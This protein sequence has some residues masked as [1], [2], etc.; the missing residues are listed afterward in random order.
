M[1]KPEDFLGAFT[2]LQ[3]AFKFLKTRDAI[4][5]HGVDF[6]RAWPPLAWKSKLNQAELTVELRISFT[7][8]I[9]PPPRPDRSSIPDSR[10]LWSRFRRQRV[11]FGAAEGAFAAGRARCVSEADSPSF[12]LLRVFRRVNRGDPRYRRDTRSLRGSRKPFRRS[13]VRSARFPELTSTEI[14]DLSGR[15]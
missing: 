15:G 14:H 1:V 13:T 10:Y 5:A 2:F 11:H 7:T 12:A 9:S 3:D 4:R 6:R 8:L